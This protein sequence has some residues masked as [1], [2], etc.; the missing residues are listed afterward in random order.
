MQFLSFLVEKNP[1]QHPIR[2]LTNV[3]P[4]HKANMIDS[5]VMTEI[6]I[7]YSPPLS[8]ASLLYIN[9]YL[10]SQ[11]LFFSQIL[12]KIFLSISFRNF[13]FQTLSDVL[14]PL[15]LSVF[16]RQFNRS[17]SN[18]SYWPYR[19]LATNIQFKTCCIV[20]KLKN[21]VNRKL[22]FSQRLLTDQKQKSKSKKRQK[23]QNQD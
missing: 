10:N 12:S 15:L 3:N 22:A 19:L 17:Y 16:L 4:S 7:H 8:D 2:Q 6:R 11:H 1:I 9:L 13:Y 20:V 21:I 18:I 14:Q 5:I 23:I